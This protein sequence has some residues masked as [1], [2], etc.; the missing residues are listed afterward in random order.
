MA[1]SEYNVMNSIETSQSSL[2]QAIMKVLKRKTTKHSDKAIYSK[3]E[4]MT[5]LDSRFTKSLQIHSPGSKF[6]HRLQSKT[7]IKS[8]TGKVTLSYSTT[9]NGHRNTVKCM[10]FDTKYST[11]LFS[12]SSDY[13]IK[14]W[15]C[16]SFSPR[17]IVEEDINSK[18]SDRSYKTINSHTKNINS[19]WYLPNSGVLISSGA[20]QRICITKST[21][22]EDFEIVKTYRKKFGFVNNIVSMSSDGYDIDETKC[23]L[24]TSDSKLK[25]VDFNN[26]AKLISQ[27]NNES[28]VQY[29]KMHNSSNYI[30]VADTTN[31]VKLYDVRSWKLANTFKDSSGGKITWIEHFD[32]DTFMTSSEDISNI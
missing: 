23:I 29:L 18:P 17:T 15:H 21:E 22:N 31:T 30:A 20:D 4:N 25:I 27:I 19:L 3:S 12:G 28:P 26:N 13:S 10:A 14:V 7:S 32:N 24:G 1:N 5:P 9:L 11:N 16:T 2:R 8:S 6:S